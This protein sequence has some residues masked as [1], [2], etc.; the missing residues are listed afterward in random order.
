MGDQKRM[1]FTFF[2]SYYESARELPDAERLALYDA[3]MTNV[4]EGEEPEVEGIVKALYILI[5]PILSKSEARAAAGRAGGKAKSKQ[6]PS[7]KK[8][9]P[10]QSPRDKDKDEDLDTDR[11]EDRDEDVDSKTTPTQSPKPAPKPAK[12]IKYADFVSM[13]NDEHSSLV[14]KVGEA[15]AARCIEILDNYKGAN[16]KTYKSDYRAILNWTVGRYREELAKSAPPRSSGGKTDTLGVLESMLYEG[17][18]ENK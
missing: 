9:K 2:R 3:L 14:A 8:A 13:T 17:G 1:G 15:G 16:G 12:K 4:F 6:T 18:G 5:E 7:K 10:K 11:D